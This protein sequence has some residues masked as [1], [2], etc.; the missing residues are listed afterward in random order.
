[1]PLDA[2]ITGLGV[3]VAAETALA[4]LA[5]KTVVIEGFGKVGGATALET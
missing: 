3:T 2:F 4:G 1:M 5:G